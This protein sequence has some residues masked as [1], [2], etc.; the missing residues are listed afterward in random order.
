[1]SRRAQKKETLKL[2]FKAKERVCIWHGIGNKRTVIKICEETLRVRE[3]GKKYFSLGIIVRQ[4]NKMLS[5]T[6]RQNQ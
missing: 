2:N 5:F 6:S 1:M 3:K 4:K